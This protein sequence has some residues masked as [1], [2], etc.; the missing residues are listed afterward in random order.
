MHAAGY[1][2]PDWTYHVQQCL[3]QNDQTGGSLDTAWITYNNLFHRDGHLFL[4]KVEAPGPSPFSMWPDIATFATPEITVGEHAWALDANRWGAKLGFVHKSFSAE[5]GWLGS[6]NGLP[7]A[8]DFATTPGTDKTFQWKV[9]H[10]PANRPLEYGLFGSLRSYTVS[11]GAADHYGSIAGYVEKDPQSNGVPGFL[12]MY[13]I[14]NDANPGL[15]ALGNQL[16]AAQSHALSAEIYEPIFKNG[17]V[18]SLRDEFTTDG[19][20]TFI[21]YGNIDLAFNVPHVPY[22]HGYIEAGLGGHS[23]TPSG[24]PDWRWILWWTTPIGQ[25]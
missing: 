20:G 4:G 8:A 6:G 13:Q 22:V 5:A 11:T 24:G 14:A 17:A 25:L 12:A 15:D 1:A 23:G 18:L 3:L 9:A 10:S 2:G 16:P 19:L 7:T 21:R